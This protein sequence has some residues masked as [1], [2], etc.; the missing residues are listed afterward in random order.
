M[1]AFVV[2]C[3]TLVTSCFMSVAADAAGRQTYT[4]THRHTD[5]DRH[6]HIQTKMEERKRWRKGQKI[7]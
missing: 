6:T 4:Y 5:T 2:Q 1:A 3:I 7:V